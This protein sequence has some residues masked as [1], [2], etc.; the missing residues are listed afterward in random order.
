MCCWRRTEKI[1]WTDR[2]RNE[3][4]LHRI[5]ED[6]NILHTINRRKAKWIGHVLH[7]NYLLKRVIEGKIEGSIEVSGRRGRR[8]KQLLHDLK[9]IRGYRKFKEAALART[10]WGTRFGRN[11]FRKTDFGMTEFDIASPKFLAQ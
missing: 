2:V 10:L 6:R 8:R 11:N 1:T 7:R 3:E 5:K 9:E 4:V